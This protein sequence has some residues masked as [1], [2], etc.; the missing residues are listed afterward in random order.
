M[1]I[2]DPADSGGHF[3]EGSPG[4]EKMLSCVEVHLALKRV[5]ASLGGKE[6][7]G[8]RITKSWITLELVLQKEFGNFDHLKCV[9]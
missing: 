9:Y 7:W 5:F 4:L 2:S 6:Q 3:L 1:H 8:S